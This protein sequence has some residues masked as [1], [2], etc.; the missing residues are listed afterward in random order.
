MVELDLSFLPDNDE[1]DWIFDEIH[2]PKITKIRKKETKRLEKE[3]KLAKSIIARIKKSRKIKKKT[4]Q[5]VV[6]KKKNPVCLTDFFR[7]M[8][9]QKEH[10]E[11]SDD[12]L[13]F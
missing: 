10:L 5:E 7:K 2:D 12:D 9:K 13:T 6:E 1:S 3:K 8:P 4:N 11:D